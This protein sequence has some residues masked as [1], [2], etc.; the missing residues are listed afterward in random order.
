MKP[1][2]PI[3]KLLFCCNPLLNHLMPFCED[4]HD[5]NVSQNYRD[6]F[7]ADFVQL[8]QKA[9]QMQISYIV[10][11]H[12]KYAM[13]ALIDEIILHSS[14]KGSV[15]WLGQPLQLY[16]FAEHLAGEGFFTR[17]DM[18][19][20]DPI[21]NCDLLEVYYVCLQL[22]FSGIYRIKGQEFLQGLQVGL[23]QQILTA[24]TQQ[25]I[26]ATQRELV[27][28]I[29]Q[30]RNTFELSIKMISILTSFIILIIYVS[31]LLAIDQK[32]DQAVH[33]IEHY[34]MSNSPD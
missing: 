10:I 23:Y 30:K 33:Q 13:A 29:L 20:L 27:P 17:L 19:R 1:I 24:R 26:N 31:Y 32:A 5:N 16:F 4:A 22:G 3:N 8:E 15:E 14:W 9:N 11:Q 28:D 7:L 21:N 18:L 25:N 12:V 6:I 34:R 2:L